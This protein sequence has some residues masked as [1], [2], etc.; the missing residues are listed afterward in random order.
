[1]VS[2]SESVSD[3]EGIN[4]LGSSHPPGLILDWLDNTATTNKNMSQHSLSIPHIYGDSQKKNND[5]DHDKGFISFD[6]MLWFV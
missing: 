6:L 3:N 1:M 2:L 4:E 5:Q